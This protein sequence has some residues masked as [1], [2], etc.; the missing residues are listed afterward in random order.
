MLIDRETVN[1]A[2][3]DKDETIK[4][5]EA[6]SLYKE[7]SFDIVRCKECGLVYVNPRQ[8]WGPKKSS[9]ENYDVAKTFHNI[10]DRDEFVYKF[11]LDSLGRHVSKGRILDIGCSTGRFLQFARQRGW[12][13]YGV[14]LNKSC[15][16]F[17]RQNLINVSRGEVFEAQ[18]EDDFFDAVVM[19]HSIEHL[20]NLRKDFKKIS[21]MVKRGGYIYIMTPNFDNYLIRFLQK[22]GLLS[23]EIDKLDP[24]GHPY[25]FTRK[26][27]RRFLKDNC[28]DAVK[29]SASVSGNFLEKIKNRV[30]RKFFK[31]F[32][33]ILSLLNGGSTLVAIAKRSS[34]YEKGA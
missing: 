20:Y 9:L 29:I 1:C 23:W 7:E 22:I 4:L 17:C 6:K 28:F 30:L 34:D 24:T 12:D 5:S 33:F 13:S 11:V 2:I 26:T 31:P 27:L 3:C 19:I 25:M 15:A 8:V 14:E 18:F 16:E 10:S 21:K 32:I